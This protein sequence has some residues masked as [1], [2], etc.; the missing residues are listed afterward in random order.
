MALLHGLSTW[1]YYMALLHGLTTWPYYMA[2]LHGLTTWPYYMALL[3]GLTTW[4]YY[5]AAILICNSINLFYWYFS[6][7]TKDSYNSLHHFRAISFRL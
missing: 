7:D 6:L 1:P 5:L 3:H 2:L 4:P